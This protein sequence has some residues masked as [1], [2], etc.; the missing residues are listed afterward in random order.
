MSAARAV[1]LTSSSQ[2][3][4]FPRTR[5]SPFLATDPKNQTVSLIIATLPE[6]PFGKSFACHTCVPLPHFSAASGGAFLALSSPSR[7]IPNPRAHVDNGRGV[8]DLLFGF[9]SSRR[10]GS[11]QSH[12]RLQIV[13]RT[14]PLESAL[15]KSGGV[16]TL[17]FLL[18]VA[19]NDRCKFALLFSITSTM[20][21]PQL[22]F[23]TLLQG[24]GTPRLP[25]EGSQILMSFTYNLRLRTN[26]CLSRPRQLNR[27]RSAAGV[28][29]VCPNG[30]M[31]I[32][33][34]RDIIT[35]PP[36]HSARRIPVARG[37]KG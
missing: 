28:G 6:T 26:N 19:S 20:L 18:S 11:Q 17:L 33:L 8:K 21:P 32:N 7:V 30:L 35:W 16:R 4:A 10:I 2:A 13:M 5:L 9:R 22:F 36:I 31:N 3:S 37:R 29:T 25:K 12:P 23:F 27:H 24:V 15:T 1:L 14:A 34:I